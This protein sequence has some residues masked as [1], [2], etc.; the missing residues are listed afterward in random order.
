M[1]H[2][3]ISFYLR[4][5]SYPAAT[6]TAHVKEVIHGMLMLG[7]TNTT[8]QMKPA[9]H[10]KPKVGQTEGTVMLKLNA[11]I[12]HGKGGAGLWITLRFKA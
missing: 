5:F 12:V 1:L 7:Y 9:H 3:L 10:N 4:R 2:G 8:L 11:S 6:K